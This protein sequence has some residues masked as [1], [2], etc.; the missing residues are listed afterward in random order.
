MLKI[1]CHSIAIKL[2]PG[3]AILYN[4]TGFTC[5]CAHIL[6]RFHHRDT[7]SLQLF[8]SDS[9]SVLYCTV[10]CSDSLVYSLSMDTSY[11]ASWEASFVVI[12]MVV[13]VAMY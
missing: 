9:Y 7:V 6:S 5:N 11:L 12:I 4:V 1:H 2:D 13:V 8:V 10:G 3:I